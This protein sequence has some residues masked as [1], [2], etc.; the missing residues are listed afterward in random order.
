MRSTV[1]A[2]HI[3]MNGHVPHNIKLKNVDDYGEP[4]RGREKSRCWCTHCNGT[5]EGSFVDLR[6]VKEGEDRFIVCW[7]TQRK[8]DDKDAFLALDKAC[9]KCF[10][11]EKGDEMEICSDCYDARRNCSTEGCGK[12]VV[13]NGVC[14]QHGANVKKCSTKGCGKRV[15]NNG[16]CIEHG[17][18]VKNCSTEGCGKRAV[19]K[20][21]CVQHGAT[22]KK[23]STK[24]CGKRVVNNGVCFEHGAKVNKK[25]CSTEGCDKHAQRN[26]LCIT[27]GA[28]R[29]EC[30]SDG[31][32]KWVVNNGLCVTHGATVKNCSIEGCGKRVQNNG[33]CFGH[34]AKKRKK[35]ECSTAG[36]T[37]W[38][39]IGGLCLKHKEEEEAGQ[40]AKVN[41]RHSSASG[42][43]VQQGPKKKQKTS[44]P[45]QQQNQNNTATTTTNGMPQQHPPNYF[46]THRFGMMNPPYINPDDLSAPMKQQQQLSKQHT[47]ILGATTDSA[48]FAPIVPHVSLE[49]MSSSQAAVLS[50]AA[51]AKDALMKA[52]MQAAAKDALMKA[53]MQ[54]LNGSSR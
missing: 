43:C 21:V 41:V 34:G 36:C 38:V 10:L 29:R 42:K 5:R 46:P 33:V 45:P 16:V 25:R 1:D 51:A 26:G 7:S 37:K 3:A 20:G 12:R 14:V 48:V 47:P 24:G 15:V 31:C 17:A 44:H 4:Y 11:R 32:T 49:Q 6:K 18:T 2:L 39:A 27:H 30:S 19:N 28:K 13:N 9:Q 35:R 50:S 22:V 8:D 52:Y 54:A 23:C 53:Y 40:Y